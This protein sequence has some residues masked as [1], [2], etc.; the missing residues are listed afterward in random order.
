MWNLKPHRTLKQGHNP[1]GKDGCASEPAESLSPATAAWT[2]E[3]T[4][5]PVNSF[6]P[7]STAELRKVHFLSPHLLFKKRLPGGRRNKKLLCQGMTAEKVF[8]KSKEKCNS[9]EM[10]E[11]WRRD[12]EGTTKGISRLW[13]DNTKEM[14]Q[15][16]WKEWV[17]KRRRRIHR[18]KKKKKGWKLLWG[19]TSNRPN[20][21][22]CPN[23]LNTLCL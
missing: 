3:L 15:R 1:K 5:A 12:E 6:D 20:P 8:G 2:E 13:E 23:H 16:K 17:S 22:P 18:V 10:R 14:E 9:G 11:I 19:S 4:A 21:E 7:K